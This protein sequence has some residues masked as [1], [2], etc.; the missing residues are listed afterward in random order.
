MAKHIFSAG[1]RS[2]EGNDSEYSYS[3]YD[4]IEEANDYAECDDI[5]GFL[6]ECLDFDKN[7]FS[8]IPYADYSGSG[9]HDVPEGAYVLLMG[10]RPIELYWIGEATDEATA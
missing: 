7:D 8:L 3:E 5:Q 6:D 10:D 1:L 9:I 2:S 4:C